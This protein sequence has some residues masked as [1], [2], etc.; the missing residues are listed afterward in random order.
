MKPVNPTSDIHFHFQYL[1]AGQRSSSGDLPVTGR[2][3]ARFPKAR[4]R[5]AHNELACQWQ[6]SSGCS[7]IECGDA[8]PE[9]TAGWASTTPRGREPRRSGPQ[10]PSALVC[11]NALNLS[12]LPCPISLWWEEGSQGTP[13]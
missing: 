7:R 3:W 10:C 12:S 5:D 4:T 6:E 11:T 8:I 13:A 1:A 9:C 2:N